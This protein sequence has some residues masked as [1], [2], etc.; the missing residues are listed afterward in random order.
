MSR[1]RV[2]MLQRSQIA[3]S[4]LERNVKA[5]IG[6]SFPPASRPGRPPH[7]R[8]GALQ[9][10]VHG[11]ARVLNNFRVRVELTV[12]AFYAPFLQRGTR[13]MAA[14]PFIGFAEDART[15]VDILSGRRS[16]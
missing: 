16:S 3:A 2:V 4:V 9:R 14:R 12:A 7:R 1:T 10:G 8:T 15:V 11:A 13:R 5:R 6:T